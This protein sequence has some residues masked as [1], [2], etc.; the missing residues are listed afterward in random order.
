M[1]AAETV[2]AVTT[3]DPEVD[4]VAPDA[5]FLRWLAERSGGTWVEPGGR[6]TV[7]Q[8]PSAGRTVWER[9][10]TPL[11][12]APVLALWVLLCGGVAWIVRRRAGLR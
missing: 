9:R 7:R 11:W 10:E 3:R 1:G 5:A 8:D 4:E 2:F 12:R 6:G